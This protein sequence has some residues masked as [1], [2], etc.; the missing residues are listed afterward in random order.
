L[1]QQALYFLEQVLQ[2]LVQQK[3]MQ[4]DFVQLQPVQ[5][6]LTLVQTLLLVAA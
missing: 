3:M 2:Q 6:A 5:L 4:M 1:A